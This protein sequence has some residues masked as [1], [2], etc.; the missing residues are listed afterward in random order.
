MFFEQQISILELYLNDRVT[1]NTGVMMLEIQLRITGINDIYYIYIYIY[2]YIY[3]VHFKQT[4]IILL[5]FYSILLGEH[6]RKIT[7]PAPNLSLAVKS[8][9]FTYITVLLLA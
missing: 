1:L 2:I 8:D 4:C 3:T 9:S 5:L 6:K 7:L